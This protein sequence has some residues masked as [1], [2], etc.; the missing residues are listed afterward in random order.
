MPP[1]TLDGVGWDGWDNMG[2]DQIGWD[3]MRLEG[4]LLLSSGTAK[5]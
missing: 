4:C 2:V 1:V 3:G 5:A